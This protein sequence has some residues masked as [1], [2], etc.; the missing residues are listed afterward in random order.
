MVLD[1]SDPDGK[2]VYAAKV[3]SG[4]SAVVFYGVDVNPNPS[5][6]LALSGSCNSC[7][8]GQDDIEFHLSCSPSVRRVTTIGSFVQTNSFLAT[9]SCPNSNTVEG[10]LIAYAV[11]GSP[12]ATASVS[13]AAGVMGLNGNVLS[14]VSPSDWNSLALPISGAGGLPMS[15][16]V[17]ALDAD[18]FPIRS[19]RDPTSA[20][21][22]DLKLIKSLATNLRVTRQVKPTPL[23]FISRSQRIANSLSDPGSFDVGSL[24]IPQ[25]VPPPS[26]AT[27][28]QPEFSISLGGGPTGDAV[29]VDLIDDALTR[30]SVSV[31]PTDI[32]PLRFPKVPDGF[33][34]FVITQANS[35]LAFHIDVA[36]A[37]D[38]AAYLA[39][40]TFS[41]SAQPLLVQDVTLGGVSTQF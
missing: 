39:G 26:F 30:W 27:I 20:A 41:S 24:A 31:P 4:V 8:L 6:E 5:G 9:P 33:D 28:G 40:G 34:A 10:T 17:E 3:T 12:K 22:H 32:A 38:Y 1:D 19:W 18:G 13:G 36:D 21:A 37:P 14:A 35:T 11:D 25:D 16:V 2:R 29:T 7:T 15:R 23:S